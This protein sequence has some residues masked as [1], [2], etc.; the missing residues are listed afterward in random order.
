MNQNDTNNQLNNLS[1]EELQKTQVINLKDLEEIVRIEKKTS[2]KPAI[3]IGIIGLS[4]LFGGVGVQV[5][6]TLKE[7]REAEQLVEQRRAE[8]IVEKD[9]LSCEQTTS[10]AN[11]LDYNYSITYDFEDNKLVGSTKILSVTPTPN[12]PEGAAEVKKYK[13]TLQKLVSTKKEYE[14]TINDIPNGFVITTNID[15]ENLDLTKIKPENTKDKAVSI[16][17]KKGD[18]KEKIMADMKAKKFTCK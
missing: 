12:K 15:Y 4:L 17:Y 16:D 1:P 2:K 9:Y 3:I 11:S 14:I 6:N 7:K 18:S 8:E 10:P 13:D 5:S